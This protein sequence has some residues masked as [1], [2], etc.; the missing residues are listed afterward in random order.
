M[1]MAWRTSG[2]GRA[3]GANLT[4]PKALTE[5]GIPA[6]PREDIGAKPPQRRPNKRYCQ[7][8]GKGVCSYKD[9]HMEKVWCY[10]HDHLTPW[11]RPYIVGTEHAHAV[12][13]RAIIGEVEGAV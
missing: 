6:V 12:P 2:A 10:A 4:E 8:C 11:T 3:R 5:N 7:K 1:S 9:A 13:G